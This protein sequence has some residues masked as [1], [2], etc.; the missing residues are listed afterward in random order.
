MH[1]AGTTGQVIGFR[2]A[3]NQSQLSFKKPQVRAKYFMETQLK[4]I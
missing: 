4:S 2:R 1:E 3:W